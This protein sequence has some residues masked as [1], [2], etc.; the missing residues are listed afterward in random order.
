MKTA[1][2]QSVIAAINETLQTGA[3]SPQAAKVIILGQTN[4][5]ALSDDEKWQFII[6][7]LSWFR[8][9]DQAHQH[10]L[11]GNIDSSVWDGYF[12]HLQ[13]TL[14]SE[15][16]QQW[17]LTRRMIFTPAFRELIDAEVNSES[18]EDFVLPPLDIIAVMQR[19]PD[20]RV[21]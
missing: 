4:F 7:L 21:S 15:S 5:E 1:T 6:W 12:K 16:V 9:M 11:L 19:D 20:T 17:W 13:G 3:A 2:A 18:S 8:I 10:Q 14:R